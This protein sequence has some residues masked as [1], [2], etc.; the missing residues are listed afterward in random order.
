MPASPSLA[1]DRSRI[2]ALAL[3]TLIGV[4]DPRPG[5][6]L[7]MPDSPRPARPSRPVPPEL[8]AALAAYRT[9]VVAQ[10]DAF[11]RET[12]RFV[13]AIQAGQLAEAR[14]LYAPARAPYERIEPVAAL[15]PELIKRLDVR[16]DEFELRE[17]DPAF[18]GFHRL[19]MALFTLGTTEGL[20]EVAERLTAETVT[21][22]DRLAAL[23]I[24]PARAVG[25][26]SALIE[27]IAATKISGEEE[28]YSRTDLWDFQ[29][30][31][32]G[33]KVVFTLLRPLL[34]DRDFV[35][36]VERSYKR[37]EDLLARYRS[38]DGGFQ[39]YD[40][41]TARDR[42]ALKGPITLLAEDLSTLRGR[43]GLD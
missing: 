17:R 4:G 28:R 27:G 6:S 36:R 34:T 20:G 13:A 1:R 40:N 42:N 31:I 15:F 35:A 18:V 39:S 26:A 11:V 32:E 43:L 21:L 9:Y 24:P 7:D 25:A 12:A 2:A 33:S 41:L 14:R 29:A 30:N 5:W 16:S 10:A 23:A 8:A 19:E 22:R 37:V 3:A 38:P